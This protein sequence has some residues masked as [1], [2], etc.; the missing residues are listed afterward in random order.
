MFLETRKLNL[1][2]PSG[3]GWDLKLC[4]ALRKSMSLSPNLRIETESVSK[5]PFF[6]TYLELR[7]IVNVEE[8]SDS[9]RYASSS[10]LSKEV[11]T[12][13]VTCL[14][15]R[16]KTMRQTPHAQFHLSQYYY[17]FLLEIHYFS[18]FWIMIFSII[19]IIIII[20]IS[21]SSSS[22]SSSSRTA[23]MFYPVAV[24]LQ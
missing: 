6:S 10:E 12:S 16:S 8:S 19:I 18:L 15:P 3:E 21:N 7:S 4:W 24:L 1:L 11:N 9:L 20:I 23:N 14:P 17:V 2:S 22:S 5:T 13:R